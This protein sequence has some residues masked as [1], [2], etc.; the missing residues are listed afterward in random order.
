MFIKNVTI[1]NKTTNETNFIDF[2][3]F[4]IKETLEIFSAFPQEVMYVDD[5]V[6]HYISTEFLQK[7]NSVFST[8][9]CGACNT[10]CEDTLD[11]N[12]ASFF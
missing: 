9:K 2:S 7:I 4:T 12:I 10:I 11:Q 6:I 1:V 3:Q 8:H 5:G